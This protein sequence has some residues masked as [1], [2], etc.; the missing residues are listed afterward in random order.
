VRV[1]DCAFFLTKFCRV[2]R[3]NQTADVAR[4]RDLSQVLHGRCALVINDLDG[5]NVIHSRIA[6]LGHY[7]PD[8]IITNADLEKTVATSDQWIRD[9]TGIEERHIAAPDETSSSLAVNASRLA[10]ERARI[11]PAELDLVIAATTTP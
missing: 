4:G 3:V 9:R 5:A 7:L 1:F 10:L 8:R 2:S 6:G 11:D